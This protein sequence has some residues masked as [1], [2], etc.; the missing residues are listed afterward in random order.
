MKDNEEEV[1]YA[2]NIESVFDTNGVWF[3]TEPPHDS[4]TWEQV[5]TSLREICGEKE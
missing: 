2:V 5:D 3:I 4:D 1:R